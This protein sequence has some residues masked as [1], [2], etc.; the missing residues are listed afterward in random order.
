MKI[1]KKIVQKTTLDKQHFQK[2]REFDKDEDKI[3]E[4]KKSL[5]TS[6]KEL[7]YI[8]NEKDPSDY[9]NQDIIRRAKLKDDID[10]LELEIENISS[11]RNELLYIKQTDD[12]LDKYF[13]NSEKKAEEKSDEPI[14]IDIMEF[15]KNK[16][17]NMLEVNSKAKLDLYD[18]YMDRID[19]TNSYQKKKN[20]DICSD[21]KCKGQLLVSYEDGCLICSLCGTLNGVLFDT[22]KVGN[23]E[24]GNEKTVYA[25]KRLNHLKEIINQIQG[26]ESVEIKDSIYADIT[27][28]MNRR[29]LNK[30]DIDFFK[31]KKILKKLK[32][33]KYYEHTSYIVWR[34]CG[35]LPPTFPRTVIDRIEKMFNL[36]Q[37]PFEMF[38]PSNRKNFLSYSYILH[39]FFDMMNMPEYL[40]YFK[41][42]KNR[43]KRREQEKVFKQ[44]CEYLNWP[45]KSSSM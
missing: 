19:K 26:Q 11:G 33:D 4:L 45:F 35:I 16:G 31:M 36:I 30:K 20:T 17:N 15:M 12:I 9:T 39:K 44:I 6:K 42:L 41:L 32:Y 3:T 8:E 34:I 40:V 29:K 2:I 5:R 38:R 22:E 43:K 28:E 24:N 23:K 37:K 18:E 21:P 14:K 7:S 25:Y 13:S 1:K 27:L 10:K